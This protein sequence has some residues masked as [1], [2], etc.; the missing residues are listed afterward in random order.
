LIVVG[1]TVQPRTGEFEMKPQIGSQLLIV[2]ALIIAFC[3]TTQAQSWTQYDQGTPPQHA[4]GVSPLGSYISN[5]LG[6]VNLSNGALNLSLPMGNVGGRGF[7]LPIALN[8]SSKVWSLGHETVFH[9]GPCPGCENPEALMVW[10]NYGQG[11]Y[12]VSIYNRIAPGWTINAAPTLTS[13][14]VGISQ[15]DGSL[16]NYQQRLHKLTVMLPDKGEIE[17]RDDQTDGKPLAN[18]SCPYNSAEYR[19]RR[20]HA[21]DGSGAIFIGDNDN[22][23]VNFDVAGTLIT[24]EG[25]RYRFQ[26]GGRCVS[27]TDRNGNKILINQSSDPNTNHYETDYVD[28]LGRTTKVEINAPD[29]A[30]SS[31]TLAVLVTVQGYQG[32]THYYKVKTDLLGSHIRSDFNYNQSVPIVTGTNDPFGV[33][34]GGNQP[35][36]SVTLFPDSPCQTQQ[37]ISGTSEVKEVA[38]PDGRSLQ[39][40][41]NLYGEVAEVLLP[42]GGKLQYDYTNAYLPSG[43]TMPIEYTGP[44]NSIDDIDRAVTERRTYADGSNLEGTST[45]SFGAQQVSGTNYACTEVKSYSG[46]STSGTVLADQRHF[47]RS[48]QRYLY[49]NDYSVYGTGNSIWS[50]GVEWRTETRDSNGSVISATEQDWSQRAPVSWPAGGSWPQEQPANDNRVSETRRYLDNGSFAKNDTFYDNVNYPRANNVAEVW[51]Y[52]FDQSLKRRTTT[53]YMTG[54]YQS[55]DSIHLVRLPLV[56]TVYDGNNNL[57]AQSTNEYDNY[58]S[59][60]NHPQLQDYGTVTGHDPSY[61]TG[62]MARGNLTAVGHWLNTTSNTIYTYLG[63]D[64]LGNPVSN[65]DALGN[66]T[67]LSYVD[68]FGDGS[69]PG[70][71]GIGSYGATY[72]M[73]TLITSPPPQRGQPQQTARTQYDFSGG[74]LTGFKDRNGVITQTIYNDPFDRP[75]QVKAALGIAGVES[76]AVMYYAPTTAFGISL[77]NNDVL[78]AKDQTTLDDATLRSW[79]HTDGFGRTVQAW[80][81]D[82]LGDDEV[83]TI[84]D[85]LSRVK[86]VSNPFRP[87][88][89]ESAIYTTTGYD[90]ASRILSVTSPDGAPVNTA[91]SGNRVL[92]ADQSARKRISVTD[93]LGRLKEVWEVT[94]TDS[95]SESVSFPGY[96]DVTAGYVT[97]YDYDT[98]D[99]LTNVSQRIGTNGTTQSRS[100]VYDSLKRLTSATNPESGTV[101]YGTLINSQCQANGYDANGNLVYK[102]D[103]RGIL[104]TYGYDALTRN[105]SITYTNDP[106]N[107]PAVTRTYDNLTNGAYGKGRLWSTQTSAG[108]LITID[109]YDALGR[110]KSQKQQFYYNNAWSQPYS[111]GGIN[112]DLAG[113]ITSIT[114]PSQHTVNYKYDNAGRLGDKDTT[115][116]AFTGNLGDGDPTQRNYAQGLVY[117][118]A[119]RLKQEQLGTATP[120]YNQLAYNSRGQLAEILAGTETSGNASFNRGMIVNDYS[121]QCSGAGCNATDNN[122]NLRR[123]TVY[124][125]ND[126]QNNS[127][128]SWSQQYDYDSLNRLTQVTED[129]GQTSLNWHQGYRYDRFGNRR[130]DIDNTSP[131]IPHPDFEV[132]VTTNRLLA[133]GDSALT[134]SNLN[135]R[136]MRYDNAGNLTNDNWSSYG[137]ASPGVATRIYDAE[138]RMTSAQDSTGGIT[139]YTYNAE[140]RRV[141]RS[142]SGQPEVWQVYG[143]GGELLAEYAANASPTTPQ[144]EYGYRNGQ[145]LI[146]TETG[147]ASAPGPSALTATPS[148][149]GASIT[150]NWTPVS[151]AT[152]Y[153]VERAT[154]KDGPYVFAGHSSST[155]LIDPGVSGTAYLYKV[156]AANS[157]DI[158]TSS[159]SNIALGVAV[160]FTDS[161]IKGFA[162]D[163]SGQ[164]VTMIKA[165]HITELRTTINAVRHLAGMGDGVWTYNPLAPQINVEDV[166]DLRTNL[167]TALT[168]LSI[169]TPPYATDPTL[170]GWHEDPLNATPIRAAHIRELRTRATIGQGGSG[171]SGSSFQIHWLVADQLGTPRMIFDQTG[172]LANASRHDY[173]PFG[174][175]LGVNV[176]GRT[177]A[178]GYGQVDGIRQQFTGQQRDNETS[179]DYFNARYYSSI[180]GRFTSADSFGGRISNPQSLNLYAYVL[181]NPL[182]WNDPTGHQKETE[183]ERRKKEAQKYGYDYVN[184]VLVQ[185]SGGGIVFET[186]TVRA[187]SNGPLARSGWDWVP[188][189]GPFRQMGWDLK[190]GH[191]A[192]ALGHFGLAAVEGATLLSPV[193]SGGKFVFRFAQRMFV[194]EVIEES[195]VVVAET[196]VEEA[197]TEGVSILESN[198][199]HIFREAAG[200]VVDTPAN[201]KLL[202]DTASDTRNLVG[203][204][205]FGNQVYAKTLENGQ[206]VWTYVRNGVIRN[207]GVNRV[208]RIFNL[209]D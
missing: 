54:S 107:T 61:G 84:Y 180:Q 49:V 22:G 193:R 51:A 88:Q 146:T 8:Y 133:L 40:N 130:I 86:Q 97:R 67:T 128:T 73:P 71:G 183:D 126:P 175:E 75:T 138:N 35:P 6:T 56:Q 26:T 82:P 3:L 94:P 39:F 134:G 79:T 149:S 170:K 190:T 42:T 28:Q 122:G 43:N 197:A 110:T 165:A 34:Y 92:V 62:N 155:T 162:D 136:K 85:A 140:G 13:Q 179:L 156:C 167:D 169:P 74:L 176:G 174:E 195:G 44:Y 207:G 178:Q 76:H 24:S 19:G 121:P 111:I 31:V 177:Q 127:R 23:V 58:G 145:L 80:S 27:I 17:L 109:S 48:S 204:N 118:A 199:G 10:A 68:D 18:T 87:S 81:S 135:Q 12:Q 46:S 100:F 7:S 194:T 208:P 15:C 148:T 187:N 186:V 153:R 160:I 38:L 137:S 105:T 30:N 98:L 90:F 119:S 112:Y 209:K 55:D 161:D 102:T 66:V 182:K 200:H 163:P 89:R 14:F 1:V 4:A 192:R 50:T 69:N 123:Q 95:A 131:N 152:N 53:S 83:T 198:A 65:K 201:R 159:Y 144:R 203:T 29:P 115:H 129:T 37:L 108:T 104:T 78:T 171:G 33:C 32:A 143:I 64:T 16:Y 168:Q 172:S 21:T 154:G 150:L 132:E 2:V 63:Y 93:G 158:C 41:Y 141:R 173:L 184:G 113:H 117:D 99:D 36:A 116:L 60:G 70:G 9:P 125:P 205:K 202:I 96:G 77:T 45:Y 57:M 72:A 181:N 25:L 166:R 191:D 47:F 124:V 206:Q 11:D 147:T 189:V 103:A 185:K 20:W 157:Q 114:Y 91:Y 196:V 101:C 142:I 5:D 59:D 188:V 106:A 164:T 139:N 52:D 151:G 120:I